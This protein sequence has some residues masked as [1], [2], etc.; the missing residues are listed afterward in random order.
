MPGELDPETKL[1]I[2]MLMVNRYKDLIREK[3][4]KSVSELR[5]RVSPHGDQLKKIRKK[6]IPDTEL[7]SYERDFQSAVQR[8]IAYMKEIKTCQFMIPFWMEFNEIDELKVAGVMD[9]AILMAALIRSFGSENALVK[10]TK[11]NK[12]YVAFSWHDSDYLFVPE[13]GS[14]LAGDDA[15]NA[16]RDDPVA[17]VFNDLTYENYEED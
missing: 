5:Q 12:I 13:T 2:Y 9:K 6:L 7:F 4:T 17:Y 15:N 10:V 1:N 3:E 16:F 11:K 8:A 14:L